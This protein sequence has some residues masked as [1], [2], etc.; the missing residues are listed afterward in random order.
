[1][2]KV[3]DKAFNIIEYIS[4]EPERSRALTEISQKFGIK[5]STCSVILKSLV[6]RNYIEQVSHKGGYIL[7][8]MA[9]LLAKN[10]PYKKYI[11]NSAE[12][13]LF[14]LAKELGE[15][16]VLATLKNNSRY[17]LLKIDGDQDLQIKER[18]IIYTDAYNTA[19]GRLL[20]ANLSVRELEIYIL[21]NGL[22]KKEVW[23]E[24]TNSH[25]LN[26][27]LTNLREE[28]MVVYSASKQLIQMAYPIKEGEK[29]VAAL[30]LGM[31]RFRFK[32]SHK[33]EVLKKTK[34]TAEEISK[35]LTER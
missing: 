15:T 2:I 1:M 31:P 10:G 16:I 7:G 26:A 8:G 29:V 13:L 24:A 34:K 23:K 22:P 20:L 4:E 30:G 21:R 27:E 11:I 3:I 32:G 5:Q 19:T 35:L 25:K 18:G 17:V 14:K 33:N 28:R 6:E 12:P 9:Y